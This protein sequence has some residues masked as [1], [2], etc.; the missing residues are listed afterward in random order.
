MRRL[1]V[2]RLVIAAAT[3]AGLALPAAA[4]NKDPNGGAPPPDLNVRADERKYQSAI[5]AIPD[6]PSSA[7]PWAGARTPTSAQPAETPKKRPAKRTA[8]H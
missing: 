4:Q 3:L 7:D 8:T 6:Q 5:D 1:A 2:R